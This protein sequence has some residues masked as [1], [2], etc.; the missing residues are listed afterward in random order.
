MISYVSPKITRSF[1]PDANTDDIIQYEW[2]E[3][4]VDIPPGLEIAQFDLIDL[5]SAPNTY[6]YATGLL[7]YFGI[8]YLERYFRNFFG[9]MDGLL[10]QGNYPV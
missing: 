4:A 6:I 5:T 8:F 10:L 3:P 1:I 7:S 2:A 9:L